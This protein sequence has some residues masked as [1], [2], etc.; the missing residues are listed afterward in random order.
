MKTWRNNALRTWHDDRV[1]RETQ[2]AHAALGLAGESGELA[3]LIKKHLYKP[4]RDASADAIADELGD[5]LYYAIIIAH[6]W[7]IDLEEVGRRLWIKLE[8]GHG[9]Q[10]SADKIAS[11]G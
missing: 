6:L 7:D 1:P 8:D 4:G 5:V 2:I 11:Q 3:D 9:W 10:G